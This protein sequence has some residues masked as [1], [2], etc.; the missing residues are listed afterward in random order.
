VQFCLDSLTLTDTEPTALIRAAASAGFDLV[1]LWVQP[2]PLYPRALVTREKANDCLKA[3]EETGVRVACLEAFDLS[4]SI[5]VESYRPALELGARLGATTA[6]AINMHNTDAARV[7]D[8]LASFAESARQFGLRVALEP[9]SGFATSRLAQVRELVLQVGADNEVGIVFDVYHL[10]RSGESPTEVAATAPQLFWHV[11]LSDGVACVTAEQA[12]LE[13]W[14]ERLYPG[15]GVF[16]LAELLQ[17]LPRAGT[18]SIEAPRLQ[19]ALAGMSPAEQALE[20]MAAM[21]RAVALVAKP[22]GPFQA[23]H[24]ACN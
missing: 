11:Q 15:D 2:P 9:L 8:L 22:E 6:L 19:R 4:S 21:R 18:W 24:A 20:A 16:P 10:M 5:A 23:K 13:S 12:L 7:A 17:H 3:L 1:S 14:Q